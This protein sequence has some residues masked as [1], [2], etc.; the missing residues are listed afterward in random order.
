MNTRAALAVT[1]LYP[2]LLTAFFSCG[3]QRKIDMS[4][5]GKTELGVP[6]AGTGDV[7]QTL[8][9][10]YPSVGEPPY[11]TIV[12]FHGGG[13]IMGDKESKTTASVFQATTQGYAVVSVNYRLSDE[14]TWPKQLH[15]AKAA[16]RFVRAN[17]ARYRLD[18]EKLVAW[19]ASAGGHLVE[20]LG[21]TNGRPS[22]EDLS[23]GNDGES[24]AVQG[25]VSWFGVAD[26]GGL[27][28]ART[29]L[30]SKLMGFNVARNREKTR[31][32]NP[33]D[34][35]TPG[36][37]PLLLVHG[38]ADP[39]VPYRQSVDMQKKVNQVTGKQTAELITFKGATHGDPAIKSN[40]SVARD[41]DFVDRILFGVE[42]P[43]RN[44]NYIK[45]RILD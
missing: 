44:R 34:L 6:Y 12:F 30:T 27:A 24:S 37:P 5:F 4:Q 15:D 36:F 23:M 22:F 16:I 29:I 26:V 19:G 3:L 39:I 18:T 21:A 11:K 14:A 13:W 7:R 17:A 32:A 45:I 28:G 20:M 42:N 35:V 25:V 38:T 41:L 33:I 10:T 2:A 40:E 1:A 9:I 43:Y 8:D 31:D